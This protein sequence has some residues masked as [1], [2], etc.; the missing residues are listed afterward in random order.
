M[1]GHAEE[2]VGDKALLGIVAKIFSIVFAGMVWI[3]EFPKASYEG[4]F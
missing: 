2:N 3:L 1:F 4:Q